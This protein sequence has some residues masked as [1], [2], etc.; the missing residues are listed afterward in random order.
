LKFVRAR[1]DASRAGVAPTFIADGGRVPCAGDSEPS[2]EKVRSPKPLVSPSGA[3]S[4]CVS[5][6]EGPL[7]DDLALLEVRVAFD[8]ADAGVR[9]LSDASGPSS[10]VGS[11]PVMNSSDS[12]TGSGVFCPGIFLL[13]RVDLDLVTSPSLSSLKLSGASR[14]CFAGG[15]ADGL[16]CCLRGAGFATRPGAV[17]AIGVIFVRFGRGIARTTA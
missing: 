12:P 15:A 5:L 10:A 7:V 2:D 17:D 3:G 8:T 11:P 9:S 4:S 1:I 13:G 6:P 16:G 14:D